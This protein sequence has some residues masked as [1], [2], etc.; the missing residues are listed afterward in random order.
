LDAFPSSRWSE[1]L[2][3]EL[4][5]SVRVSFGRAS[6]HVIVARSRGSELRVR[7]NGVFEDAPPDVRQAVA[8][9]LR[10][11][12]R[13][14]RACRRLDD[15]IAAVQERLSAERAR[16]LQLETAGNCHDLEEITADLFARE[17]D[18][19]ALPSGERPAVT[20]G[21]RARCRARR[22]LQLGSYDPHLHLVRV[23]PVLDQPAVP[24]FFVRYILFHELVHALLPPCADGSG[25]LVHHG[26]E[27]RRREQRYADYREAVLWQERNISRLIRSAANGAAFR[28]ASSRQSGRVARAVQRVLF[29]D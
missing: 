23:H 5:C 27:F 12:R 21:R 20:W 18:E 14:R 11:G 9:W 6:K 13:A 19:R 22:S 24:R 25:R 15:W 16:S 3:D 8:R 1:F 17:I 2:S 26:P 28:P 10:S 4:A 29:P 7:M